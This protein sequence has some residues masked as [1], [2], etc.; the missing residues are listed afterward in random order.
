MPKKTTTKKEAPEKLPKTSRKE[1]VSDKCVACGGSGLER[2]TFA[3]SPL[4][5]QCQ[6]SGLVSNE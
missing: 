5:G 4:C 1:V 6:G 3:Q 2:P